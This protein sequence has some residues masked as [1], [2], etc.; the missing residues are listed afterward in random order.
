MVQFTTLAA[1]VGMPMLVMANLLQPSRDVSAPSPTSHV[2]RTGA[3]GLVD[4]NAV[5]QSSSSNCVIF[6]VVVTSTVTAPA[7]N[8]NGN[9]TPSGSA[10]STSSSSAKPPVKTSGPLAESA[11]FNVYGLDSKDGKAKQVPVDY[12]DATGS[13]NDN[14]PKAWYAGGFRLAIISLGKK[15]EKDD[16]ADDGK[17]VVKGELFQNVENADKGKVA[18]AGQWGLKYL[19]GIDVVREDNDKDGKD[20]DDW[21]DKAYPN[22]ATILTN[23]K[24]KAKGLEPNK[25]YTIA[26]R[27]I[28]DKTIQLWNTTGLVPAHNPFITVPAED[29][30]T[31]TRY[32]YHLKD[33]AKY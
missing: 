31:S 25:Y 27:T 22:P 2:K 33:W 30:K 18:E 3:T 13:S 9:E 19:T 20:W 24:P 10:A 32:L 14:G 28:Q 5:D 21:M 11:T 29:L 1:M 7:T 16:K 4:V 6:T 26:F 17:G 15:D 23:D 8:T 12:K